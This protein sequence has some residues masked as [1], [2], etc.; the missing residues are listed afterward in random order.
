M[1][2]KSFL[3]GWLMLPFLLS[4]QQN[5]ESLDIF[6][7]CGICDMTFMRQNVSYVNYVRDP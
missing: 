3:I 2:R 7:D 5:K 6:I 4:A 1:L